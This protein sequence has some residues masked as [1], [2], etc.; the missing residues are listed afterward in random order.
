MGLSDKEA[1]VYLAILELGSGTVQQI[2]R[3]SGVARATTYLVLDALLEMGLVTKFEEENTTTFVAESP[4]YLEVVM[5]EK[6][7]ELQKSRQVLV[8]FLPKLEAF[9]RTEDDRPVVRYFDGV[10]GL[11]FIRSNMTREAE[12]GEVWYQFSPVDYMIDVFGS[13]ESI[14]DASYVKQRK[15]RGIQSKAIISTQST[16][17]REQLKKTASPKWAERKFVDPKGYTSSSGFTVSRNQ[18]GITIFGKKMGGVVIESESV[19]KMMREFFMIAWK[20]ID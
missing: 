16:E 18:V 3:K 4:R 12:K 1:A 6:E 13:E 10:E 5:D 9:I 19:A 7:Q 15:A 20:H 8:D 11:K 17:I 2:A 14:N